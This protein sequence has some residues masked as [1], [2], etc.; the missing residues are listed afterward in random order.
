[1]RGYY[2]FK[3]NGKEIGRAGNTLTTAGKLAIAN[4]MCTG[5]SNWAG[6]IAIGSLGN[7]SSGGVD[8][9]GSDKYLSFE[10]ART[11]VQSVS[12]SPTLVS[13]V[14][15]GGKIG[16]VCKAVFDPAV[17]GKIY[18]IGLFSQD[19]TAG[20]FVNPISVTSIYE[21]WSYLSSTGPDVWTELIS[22]ADA[23]GGTGPTGRAGADQIIFANVPSYTGNSKRLRIDGLYDFSAMTSSDKFAIACSTTGGTASSTTITFNTDDSNYFSYA[24]G[25]I[26]SY[27]GYRILSYAKSNWSTTGMVGSPSWDNINS[28]QILNTGTVVTRL[29]GI[30][31]IE[32]LADQESVLISHTTLS[33]ATAITKVDGTPLEIEYYLEVF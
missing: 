4:S 9:T 21:P 15:A 7:A 19:T 30:R 11:N 5:G 18:E 28:I 16:L 29:D 33:D 8:A 20:K 14:Y 1:M 13:G 31:V 27:N 10:F 2:V 32:A 12:S 17:S 22:D 24:L 25:A 3:Q 23:F 26:T 6:Q